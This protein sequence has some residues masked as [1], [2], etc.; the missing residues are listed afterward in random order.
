M[1][2]GARGRVSIRQS[3]GG[4]TWDWLFGLLVCVVRVGLCD[5]RQMDCSSVFIESGGKGKARKKGL[6]SFR[7]L[8][9][10]PLKSSTSAILAA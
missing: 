2:G 5:L 8:P 3:L 4:R 7:Y 9:P 1:G 6:E 10:L